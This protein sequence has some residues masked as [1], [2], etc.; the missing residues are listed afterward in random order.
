MSRRKQ[1]IGQARRILGSY[2]AAA[3][4]LGAAATPEGFEEGMESAGPGRGTGAIEAPVTRA[5]KEEANEAIDIG[6]E[7]MKKVEAGDD[8]DI[9]FQ[10]QQGLEAII[11]LAGR[12]AIL[13]QDGEFMKPP[14]LWAGLT[15]V[16]DQIHEV[17]K[18]VGRID[19]VKNPNFE[20]LGTGWLA[21]KDIVITNR[22]VAVEFSKRG[23]D[24]DWAFRPPM[25]ANLNMRAELGG[26][27][28]PVFAIKAIV[29]IHEDHD[30]AVLQAEQTSG[31]E[32]LPDPLSVATAPPPTLVGSKVYVVG[33]PAWDGRRNDPEPMKRIF[34]D[35]YN[36]KRLQPGEISGD[37]L[38][39]FEVFH[40]CSTLGGNS[41][42]PVVNLETHQ[43]L[44]LHFGGR[45]LEKNH[46]V[47]MWMLQNDPLIKRA[48][49]NYQ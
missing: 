46:A 15:E 2:E 45:F 3:E 10:E 19:V 40:D 43:V 35:I 42:S 28:A 32:I 8:D 11:L 22:H 21:G 20:W 14:K 25:T 9:S 48:N 34:A 13:I 5:L 39:N 47:P 33:Y 29:G 27:D 24:G 1:V 23:A 44:G 4:T 6:L 49:L 16:R 37:S 30:L 38:D 36:V 41:G 18:R 7:A 17:I 12:P 26:E 31:A